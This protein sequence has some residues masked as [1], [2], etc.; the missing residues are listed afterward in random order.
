MKC[1]TSFFPSPVK[2]QST[3]DRTLSPVTWKWTHRNKHQ[4]LSLFYCVK[5]FLF[6]FHFCT[7]VHIIKRVRGTWAIPSRTGHSPHSQI[8]AKRSCLQ[9]WRRGTQC[10][11]ISLKQWHWPHLSPIENMMWKRILHLNLQLCIQLMIQQA[12][13]LCNTA[14]TT[15][16]WGC[17]DML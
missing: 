12:D 8:L 6:Q 13:G 10:S 2:S 16:S 5:V 7:T 11:P 1:N 14:A 4:Q 15:E 3:N 9:W 17:T